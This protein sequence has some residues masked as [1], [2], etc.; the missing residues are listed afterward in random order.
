MGA[1]EGSIGTM[2]ELSSAWGNK[3]THPEP[4][5]GIDRILAQASG[6]LRSD[7]QVFF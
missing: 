4:I 3:M 7:A 2:E 5:S 1:S 6:P